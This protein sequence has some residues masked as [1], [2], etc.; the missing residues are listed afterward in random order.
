MQE[1]KAINAKDL[2]LFDYGT[3]GVRIATIDGEFWFV[4]HDVCDTLGIANPRDA[5]SSLDDDEVL[6]VGYSDEQKKR[7]GQ[8]VITILSEPG[9]YALIMKSRKPEAK[10]FKRWITHEVLPSI[11][12]KGNY[13]AMSSSV[14]VI[15]DGAPE[16]F[17]AVASFRYPRKNNNVLEADVINDEESESLKAIMTQEI[18]T[19]LIKEYL[20]NA[21]YSCTIDIYGHS[22]KDRPLDKPQVVKIR[23][24]VNELLG[25][26]EGY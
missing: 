7:G 2:R 24:L 18:D 26:I 9:L 4:A 13:D 15:T 19:L 14:D 6:T 11:R 8:R 16:H 23:G 22:R 21:N 20:T 25:L 12:K 3:K 5:V 10:Q 17:P 1:I